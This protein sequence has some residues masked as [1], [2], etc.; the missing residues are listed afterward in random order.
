MYGN[1]LLLVHLVEIPR[2]S[3][4]ISRGVI[5]ACVVFAICRVLQVIFILFDRHFVFNN[6]KLTSLSLIFL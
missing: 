1:D 5:R 3:V 4:C 2:G 6:I